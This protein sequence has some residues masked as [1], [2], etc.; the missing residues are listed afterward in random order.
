VVPFVRPATVAVVGAGEPVTAVAG[1]A[2][3]PMYGVMTYV[4]TGPPLV[5][6]FHES[7]ADA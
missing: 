6:A 1:C 4:V 3:D 7:E 5:G 2:V